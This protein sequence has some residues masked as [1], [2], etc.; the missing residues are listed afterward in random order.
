MNEGRDHAHNVLV[1]E[2]ATKGAL[3]LAAWLALWGFTFVAAARAARTGGLR[4]R[5]V[6]AGVGAALVGWFAQSLTWLYFSSAWMVHML[7]LAFLV[8]KEGA[9][10]APGD[11]RKTGRARA[12]R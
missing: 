8:R 9:S 6:A 4:E 2:A 1:E 10:R 7:L 11:A 3:G 12:A 5:A